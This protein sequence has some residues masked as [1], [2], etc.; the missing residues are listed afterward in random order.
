MRV[1]LSCFT[2]TVFL[3]LLLQKRRRTFE[4]CK[5]LPDKDED[6]RI[7]D[8]ITVEEYR[9]VLARARLEREEN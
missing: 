1:R 4:R 2:L 8:S 9:Q 7:V 3:S 5:Y 6:K